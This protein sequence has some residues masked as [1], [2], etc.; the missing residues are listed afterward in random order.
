[1]PVDFAQFDNDGPDGIPG[2]SDDDGYVDYMVLMPKSHPD[3]FIVFNA[4][5]IATL[6]LSTP[7]TSDDKN[8]EGNSIKLDSHSGCISSAPNLNQAV[9]IIC[10]EYGHSFGARD[11][12]DVVYEDNE[13]DSA[14]I[15]F[16][17]VMGRGTLGWDWTGGPVG[18][19][20]YTRMFL[21]CIGINNANLIDL[22][23]IHYNLRTGDVAL[24]NGKVYRIWAGEKEY[25]LIEHRRNDGIFYDREIPQNG[26]LI[27]HVYEPASSNSNENR[28]VCDLEC[29]DGRYSDAGYP[30][31]TIEDPQNGCDNLDFW[32]H[33]QTYAREHAG[34]LGDATDVF[35]GIRYTRFGP[36]TNPNSDSKITKK[37]TGIK[38]SN[39]HPE[40]REMMF[41]VNTPPFIEWISVQ[42]PLIGTAFQLLSNI[43]NP[44]RDPAMKGTTLYFINY[45]RSSHADELVTVYLDSLTVDD[46]SSLDHFEVQRALEQR[47]FMNSQPLQNAK[48]IRENISYTSFSDEITNLGVTP[49]EFGSGDTIHW[50]QK[51]S[52]IVEE[53]PL[54]ET[55]ELSQN[56]PNP[57]NSRTTITYTLP[58]GG[59]VTLE[60]FNVLGQK[61]RVIDCGTQEAGRHT[62]QFDGDGLSSGIYFYRIRG[63]TISPA[64]KLLLIR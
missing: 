33:D 36:D 10:H 56:Y 17:G 40:G 55:I 20:A 14:G 3:N 52:V 59:S 19:C 60:V 31:G 51:I 22:Y 41:D 50:I 2:S 9:G 32:A 58:A 15:G 47:I 35:D 1:V 8:S 64:K 5:G 39:I 24:E 23:G 53:A 29:P 54:P 34:N 21:G 42:Y 18:P 26:I 38:I 44:R 57:F 4:D 46:L 30:F 62:L 27:W 63:S 6:P 61:V 49:G 28:K 16:W 48:I 7:Y 43:L 45:G 12:Y 25:F 11:L 13:T 37:S